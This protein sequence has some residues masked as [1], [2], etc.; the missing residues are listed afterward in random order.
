MDGPKTTPEPSPKGSDS[1]TAG[2]TELTDSPNSPAPTGNPTDKSMVPRSRP[3]L[4]FSLAILGGIADLWSKSFIFNW[5]G[6]PREK[7]IWWIVDGY[8]GIETTVNIG[9]VFGL[10]AGKGTIFAAFSIIAA[11]GICVWLFWFKA[12]VSLWL[13][14]AL[15][16]VTGGIIGNLYDRLGLWWVNENGYLLE[17]QSGVRDW[18]L[19]QIPGVPFLDPWPNFNIA[20]SLLVIGAG[21][22]LYQSFFPGNLADA[23]EKA[24]LGSDKKESESNSQKA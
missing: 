24:A 17:W 9:A 5:R 4:F 2:A 16:L 6:L 10:G 22:L 23:D 19:F 8:F 15:G 7:D 11:I 1:S 18:I 14:T 13:T 21:M 3:I 20:D 12:A